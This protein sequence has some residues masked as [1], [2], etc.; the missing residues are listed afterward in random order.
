MRVLLGTLWTQPL[1]IF[2]P[3]P[4]T[5]SS[6]SPSDSPLLRRVNVRGRLGVLPR[7]D[8]PHVPPHRACG[9]LQSLWRGLVCLIFLPGVQLQVKVGVQGVRIL[10]L[11]LG[12]RKHKP[13]SRP[14][15]SS[16]CTS[17]PSSSP[18]KVFRNYKAC[19]RPLV[20]FRPRP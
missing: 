13:S 11:N 20:S 3:A 17:R 7:A 5:G 2:T 1:R 15:P 6:G 8:V 18:C 14:R 9:A 10:P 16:R 12:P 4:I 19:T